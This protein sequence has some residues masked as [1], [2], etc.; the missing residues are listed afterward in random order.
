MTQEELAARSGLSVDAIG[1]QE[2]GI[3]RAP[4]SST[5]EYLPRR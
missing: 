2:R 1:M 3:R 5:I 4:R